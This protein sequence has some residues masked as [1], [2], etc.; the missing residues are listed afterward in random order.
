MIHYDVNG[1]ETPIN[2]TDTLFISFWCSAVN[3]RCCSS[4][5]AW[6]Y[7]PLAINRALP[8]AHRRLLAATRRRQKMRKRHWRLPDCQSVCYRPINASVTAGTHRCASPVSSCRAVVVGPFHVILTNRVIINLLIIRVKQS[9]TWI[10]NWSWRFACSDYGCINGVWLFQMW[11]NWVCWVYWQTQWC[12]LRVALQH[13]TSAAC[14][15]L[16]QFFC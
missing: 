16:Q 10:T 15:D 4:C 2:F 5:S 12:M 1:I 13:T 11:F 7:V 6:Q 9:D 14:P 3:R 8:S